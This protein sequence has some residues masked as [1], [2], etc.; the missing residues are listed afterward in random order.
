MAQLSLPLKNLRAEKPSPTT[1]F[2]GDVSPEKNQIAL[3]IIQPIL[4]SLFEISSLFIFVAAIF[5]DKIWTKN[6]L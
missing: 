2:R 6:K 4:N 5:F 3:I 1:D